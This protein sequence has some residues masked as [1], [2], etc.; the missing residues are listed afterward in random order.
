MWQPRHVPLPGSTRPDQILAVVIPSY[1]V[2][3]HVLGVIARIGPEVAMIFVVDDA[4]PDGSGRFVEAECRDKRVRVIF[5]DR[6]RGVGG[7]VIS[8]YRAALAA[9]ADIVVKVDGDALLQSAIDLVI[10]L[11]RSSQDR[12]E[13]RSK[14]MSELSLSEIQANHILDMTISKLVALEK[15]K[16]EEERDELIAK[17]DD[18]EKLL[19]SENRQRKT[20]LEELREIVE[21]YATD[22]RTLIVSPNE[23]EAYVPE[24][25]PEPQVAT[26][27]ENW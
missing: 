21:L 13:A 26:T 14:L 6:N 8:G 10:Q 3:A 19:A 2:K 11:V 7:A 15:L 12:A 24:P 18:Y 20:V 23:L 16:L 4:C 9:G 5:H 17:I 27:A 25:D 1:R 22:R